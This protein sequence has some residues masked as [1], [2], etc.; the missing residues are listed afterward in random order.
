M[1]LFIYFKVEFI[2]VYRLEIFS[3]L[4]VKLAFVNSSSPYWLGLNADPPL[5]RAFMKIFIP[6]SSIFYTKA[7]TWIAFALYNQIL[8]LFVKPFCWKMWKVVYWISMNN[9]WNVKVGFCTNCLNF[10][11]R[12]T[13]L[14]YTTCA[15]WASCPMSYTR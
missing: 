10:I 14:Y 12:K 15:Y 6:C 3:I 9:K 2:W 1:Y 11:K 4:K 8:K 7:Q 5:F 13:V